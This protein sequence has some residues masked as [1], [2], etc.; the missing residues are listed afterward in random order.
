VPSLKVSAELKA[1]DRQQVVEIMCNA[2]RQLAQSIH[3]LCLPERVV[4]LELLCDVAHELHDAQDVAG[5][6]RMIVAMISPGN[7][8]PFLRR[9]LTRDGIN[10]SSSI[11]DTG[12]QPKPRHSL[13]VIIACVDD[14]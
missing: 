12:V 7:V 11:R 4:L 9:K 14:A 1:D 8:S 5:G 2:A 13:V 3:A 10:Q 6:S